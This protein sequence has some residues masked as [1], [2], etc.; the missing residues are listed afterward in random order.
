[1]KLA[2]YNPHTMI[3]YC[4]YSS[5]GIQYVYLLSY[6]SKLKLHN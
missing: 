2:Y 3:Y 6:N 4:G 1:M 5:T